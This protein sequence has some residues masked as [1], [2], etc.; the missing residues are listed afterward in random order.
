M[1]NKLTYI[2][3][4]GGVF[5]LSPFAID[6]YL[7]A[8]PVIATS[9]STGIDELEATV[10]I[11]LF[12]F[13]LGQLIL[14]PI[15]DAFG[16]QRI[17]LAGLIVFII[18]SLLVGTAQNLEQLYFWRFVQ[19]LGGAGAVG[20]FPLVRSRFGEREG[21]QV[22][23]YIMAL[24]VVAPMIAPIVGGYMLSWA[25]W[26]SIFFLLAGIGVVATLGVATLIKE[27]SNERRPLLIANIFQAYKAV[28]NNRQIVLAIL[29]GGFAFGGLFAFVA[30]SPFVY[31]TYFGVSPKMYGYL[32]ALNALSMIGVNLVN[33]QLLGKIDPVAKIFIGAGVLIFA[34]LAVLTFVAFELG[35]PAI[36]ASI[37]VFVGG[38]GFVATNAIVAALSVMPEENGT[39]AAINGALQF[40][41]GAGSSMVVSLM[42]STSALP[43]AIVMA[44][45]AALA[46]TCALA[47]KINSFSKGKPHN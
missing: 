31:I 17:L 22:I 34:G 26:N 18:A 19:A 45:C 12:G 8:L 41:I 30:G 21:A 29:S 37:V 44:G 33:A 14:G 35:L 46:F 10:A 39:V 5:M 16:R 6:M 32:V 23:S 36:V 13:A 47:L 1:Q 38:L 40:A 4:L 42:A 28:L 15:S 9:L 24:T 27:N 3:V 11:F 20:V 25:G 2:G 7:P 43:M